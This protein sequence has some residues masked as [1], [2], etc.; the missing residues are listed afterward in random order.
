VD[1]LFKNNILMRKRIKRIAIAVA[2]FIVV[3][4]AVCNILVISNASGKTFDSVEEVP[5]YKYGLLLATSP[6]TPTGAHNFYF[7]NRIKATNELYKAGKIDYIIASGGDYT[8]TQRIG[9]DE[10]AAIRDSLVARGI[11]E[12]RIFLDYEGVRTVN[13]IVNAKEV[14]GVDSVLIISQKGHNQRAI[15]LAEHYE[16]KAIGYN[17]LP[18]HIRRNRIKNDIR[19]CFARVKMFF[20]VLIDSKLQSSPEQIVTESQQQNAPVIVVDTCGLRVYYPQYTN[21]DLVCG[22][23]P[24]KEDRDVIMFAEAAF[25]GEL[26]NEFKHSNVAGDHVAKGKRERGFRC[27]RNT[28]AFVYYDGEAKFIYKNF[29]DELDRAAKHGGCGFSQEMMI[30]LGKE[31]PHS[32]KSSNSNEFRALCKIGGKIAV[33]DTKGIMTFGNFIS[34]LLSI[35]ATEALYLDMG[36]GWNYSWY[37]DVKGSPI[38]IHPVKTKY[39]TNWITFY[40]KK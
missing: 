30:H 23:M 31:V 6:I 34:K 17:A 18:S 27:K 35:G 5:H 21:I 9:C 7:D 19:E 11:P 24:S 16:L 39:A 33:I 28:G 29:S 40:R 10:P 14:Y 37:R 2:I 1:A 8:K 25:T 4:V 3:L 22:T 20:D 12:N 38:E 36:T 26:L 32:R 15:Y 13:S